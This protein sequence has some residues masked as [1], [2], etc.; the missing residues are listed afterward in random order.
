MTSQYD[1]LLELAVLARH[2]SEVVRRTMA[3]WATAPFVLVF[4]VT[5][6]IDVTEARAPERIL[7]AQ[8]YG[9]DPCPRPSDDEIVVCGREPETE[10]YRIPQQ[11]RT[12]RVTTPQRAWSN[13][14]ETLEAVSRPSRPNSCSPV[15]SGGQTG[16]FARYGDQWR[17]ERRILEAERGND[18]D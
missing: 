12:I 14:V 5:L 11:L 10:R 8:V 1:A 13:R 16:C 3:V 7:S 4:G 18:S 6:T 17:A 2:R 15:G 9:D